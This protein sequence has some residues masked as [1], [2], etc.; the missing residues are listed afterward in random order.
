MQAF[1][2]QW[3]TF[4]ESDLKYDYSVQAG[5]LEGFFDLESE[6]STYADHPDPKEFFHV[7]PTTPVPAELQT[8]TRTLYRLLARDAVIALR[9][10]QR[11]LPSEVTDR[12]TRALE[13]YVTDRHAMVLRVTHYPP[14]LKGGNPEFLASQH[15]DINLITLLPPA[16]QP[17]LQVMDEH[18]TLVDVAGRAREVVVIYGD[19]IEACTGGYVKATRHA[20]RSGADPRTRKGRMSVSFFANPA[21]DERLTANTTA[22]QLL[23]AR[24]AE[25]MGPRSTLS[26]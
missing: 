14:N 1:L 5:S 21:R 18:G 26:D 6:T 16:S 13:D 12:M 10:I 2:Q 24:L 3:R 17:G 4:F 8:A 22:G 20:V 19:M 7:F 15:E 25:V 11:S 9:R 23:D